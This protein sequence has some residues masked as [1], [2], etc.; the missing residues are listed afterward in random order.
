MRFPDTPFMK[1]TFDLAKSRG[2][3]VKLIPYII[4]MVKPP[5]TWLLYNN[6]RVNNQGI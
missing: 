1:R 3:N 5:N 6:S 2:L 4:Q